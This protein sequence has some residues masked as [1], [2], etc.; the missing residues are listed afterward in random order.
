M[1]VS[2]LL[3]QDAAFIESWLKGYFSGLGKAPGYPS[4]LMDAA[5]YSLFAGGK[6]LRP[7]LALMSNRLFD[8]ENAMI[9]PLAGALEL[10]HTYSL[11]HDDLPAMDDDDLRRGCPTCHIQ[12]DEAE[13]IL[14]GDALMTEAFAMCSALKYP[15]DRVV[16]IIR[17]LAVFA[18]FGGMVAGQSADLAAERTPVDEQGLSFI[19][20]NKTGALIIAS[21]LLPALANGAAEPLQ[22]ALT[23]YGEALGMLYQITDDILDESGDE[24]NTGKPVGSDARQGKTT[25]V[26]LH[27]LDGAR[28]LAIAW[29]RKAAGAIGPF[30]S[31]GVVFAEL[32]RFILDRQN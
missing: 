1:A 5:R 20:R 13:A 23:Q 10:I 31:R 17:E 18:G 28:K 19:H 4:R 30:K 25:F 7:A 29:C 15:A 12:Y 11:I 21:L 27:G 9:A 8:G 26:S 6:R 2:E 14:A 32:A 22:Q 16:T 3:A 24:E